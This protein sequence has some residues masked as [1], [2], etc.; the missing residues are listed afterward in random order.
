MMT[1]QKLE[2]LHD[3][4]SG[5]AWEAVVEMV[6]E[7][8]KGLEDINTIKNSEQLYFRQGKLQAFNEMLATPILVRAQLDQMLS[9]AA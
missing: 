4:F 5:D 6:E 8:K 7:A 2:K 3:M 1:Q 9:E